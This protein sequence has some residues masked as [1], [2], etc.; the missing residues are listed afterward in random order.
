[1]A[2]DKM[3]RISACI[4][5]AA[6]LA[7]NSA[8]AQAVIG[9]S[10]QESDARLIGADPGRPPIAAKDIAGQAAAS[11]GNPLWGIPLAALSA[12]QERPIFSPSRR[13]P[14]AV[15]PQAEVEPPPPPIIAQREAER[16]V[17][18]LVGTI[19]GET[20]PEAIFMD[21]AANSIVRLHVGEAE[22]GWVLRSVE[23]RT[24]TLE[25]N[26]Q[27]VTLALPAPNLEPAITAPGFLPPPGMDGK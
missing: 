2:G 12:T 19:M 26:R 24:T 13:P 18:T 8:T 4:T 10:L 15:A 17:F 25:K 1:M 11:N 14:Q 7:S 9:V 3:I 27:Q 6:L 16:P 23:A 22:A 21:Q 20:D 5:L